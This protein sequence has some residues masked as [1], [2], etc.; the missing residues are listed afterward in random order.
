MSVLLTDALRGEIWGLFDR[1]PSKLFLLE[2]I[3]PDKLENA[4]QSYAPMMRDD[5]TVIALYDDTVFGSAKDGFLLTTKRLYG[6]NI[7]ERASFL[8]V[9]EIT[10]F[11]FERKFLKSN[12]LA[13]TDTRVLAK[14]ITAEEGAAALF[15]ALQQTVTLLQHLLPVARQQAVV[16]CDSCGAAGGGPVCEYCGSPVRERRNAT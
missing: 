5:E 10:H 12:I 15:Q 14:E 13:H 2:Q 4:K 6:K 1:A 9:A 3:P 11:S 16:R 7:T 8:E